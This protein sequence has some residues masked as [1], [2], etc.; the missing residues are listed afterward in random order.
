[1]ATYGKLIPPVIKSI[2]ELDAK[3]KQEIQDLKDQISE[4]KSL[5][6]NK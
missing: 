2:Q 1:M 4:L 6:L 3:Y 5:I